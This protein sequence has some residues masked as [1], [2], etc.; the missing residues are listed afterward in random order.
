MST[1]SITPDFKGFQKFI[2]SNRGIIKKGRNGHISVTT[3]EGRTTTIDFTINSVESIVEAL[4]LCGFDNEVNRVEGIEN[5]LC[6]K[7]QGSHPTSECK[8]KQFA[9]CHH[10]DRDGHFPENCW[11]CYKCEKYGHDSDHCLLCD[12]CEMFGHTTQNCRT[13]IC[14]KCEK[15]GHLEEDCLQCTRCGLF[16]HTTSSCR[17]SL[18]TKCP[19]E[20]AH[21]FKK[22]PKLVCSICHEKGHH[23]EYCDNRECNRCGGKHL[24]RKCRIKIC[25]FCKEEGHFSRECRNVTCGFCEGDHPEP[26]CDNPHNFRNKH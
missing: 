17:T 4:Q 8:T 3:S 2:S 12:R 20:V 22:C 9:H 23:M 21:Y 11:F 25:S 19:S 6:Q 26:F 18:C 7:C 14:D 1:A 10:C 15:F 13:K 5:A 16:G 24:T